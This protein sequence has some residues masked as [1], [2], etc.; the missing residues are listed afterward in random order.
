M[1]ILHLK[2]LYEQNLIVGCSKSYYFTFEIIEVIKCHQK[3]F[4]GGEQKNLRSIKIFEL[5]NTKIFKNI[6]HKNSKILEFYYQ[7]LI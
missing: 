5:I 3:L 4:G 1:T 7:S 6:L 2:W